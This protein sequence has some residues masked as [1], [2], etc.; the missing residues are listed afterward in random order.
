MDRYPDALSFAAA[1][2]AA[3]ESPSAP[4]QSGLLA[5][6]KSMIRRGDQP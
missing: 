1:L 3:V 2:K 4:P 5:R 6:M